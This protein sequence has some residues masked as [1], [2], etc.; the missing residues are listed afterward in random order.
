MTETIEYCLRNVDS[1]TRRR[2]AA[3]TEMDTGT[4]GVEIVERRCLQRCGD[5]YR[6]DFLVVDGAIQTADSHATL[7]ASA[8]EET[9]E[10]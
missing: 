2:L 1:A 5:C 6:D 4:D 8:L 10:R 9:S 3:E 7:L